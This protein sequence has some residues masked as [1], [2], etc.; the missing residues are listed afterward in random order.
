MPWGAFKNMSDLELKAI[1][2]YLRTVQPVRNEIKQIV[3]KKEG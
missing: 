2:R 3:W 1:Y